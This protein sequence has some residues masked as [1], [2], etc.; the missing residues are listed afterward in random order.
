MKHNNKAFDQ[1]LHDENDKLAKDVVKQFLE[2]I[3]DYEIVEGD[4]YGVDL[5]VL[6]D[7]QLMATIEVERRQWKTECTYSTIHV[8]ERKQKFF[9]ATDVECFLF[10]VSQDCTVAMHCRGS[11]IIKHEVVSIE[12]KFMSAEPFFDVPKRCWGRL[13]MHKP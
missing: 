9:T 4:K 1:Q 11:E 7:D 12:N 2:L 13:A 6:N 3:S 5:I 8:P 10:S